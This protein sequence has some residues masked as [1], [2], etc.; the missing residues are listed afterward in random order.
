M[1]QTK[2]ASHI[3]CRQQLQHS[4]SLGG[5]SLCTYTHPNMQHRDFITCCAASSVVRIHH[6]L[7]DIV[8]DLS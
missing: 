3:A 4:I 2:H 7:A 8:L 6:I 5:L 1:R